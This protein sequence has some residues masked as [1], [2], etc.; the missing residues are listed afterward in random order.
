MDPTGGQRATWLSSFDGS[1]QWKV[2]TLDIASY[3]V[4]I[5]E[6]EWIVVGVP[7]QDRLEGGPDWTEMAPLARIDPFTGEMV[8]LPDLPDLALFDFYFSIE[9]QSH[10]V[11]HT[12]SDPP[13]SSSSSAT[14]RAAQFR[15]SSGSRGS[16]AGTGGPL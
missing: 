2:V 5:S 13:I 12:F 11:Y 4:A 16:G 15:H 8:P 9:G 3:P 14:R 6:E 10:A 7:E 1:Y